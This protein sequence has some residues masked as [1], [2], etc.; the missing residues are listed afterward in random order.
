MQT[1]TKDNSIALAEKALLFCSQH[2]EHPLTTFIRQKALA[3][4][5]APNDSSAYLELRVL[6]APIEH[7]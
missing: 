2:P 4:S 7:Q 5:L 1:H 6:F 3:V